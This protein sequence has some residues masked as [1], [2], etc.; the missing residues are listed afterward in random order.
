MLNCKIKL[1]VTPRF[2]LEEAME[3]NE[4]SKG[5][6]FRDGIQAPMEQ[7]HG[8][9]ANSA[10]PEDDDNDDLYGD[11]KVGENFLESFRKNEE[12]EKAVGASVQ[13]AGGKVK[14]DKGKKVMS[15]KWNNRDRSRDLAVRGDEMGDR[16]LVPAARLESSGDGGVKVGSHC[17]PSG[18]MVDLEKNASKNVASQEMIRSPTAATAGVSGNAGNVGNSGNSNMIR[19]G[20]VSGNAMG[21]IG[22]LG[23]LGA[24]PSG[25]GGGGGTIFVSHLHWW[26]TDAQLEA[27]SSKYGAVKE[28][29]CFSEPCNG[30]SKGCL[31]G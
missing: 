18:K 22:S 30:K 24:G 28:I 20:M 5:G 25:G 21:S 27:E 3:E 26:T 13:A 11:L 16:D 15:I 10:V 14:V 7:L 29:T 6:V 23:A 12:E 31:Q 1:N 9:E 17:H 4:A 19:Q 2:F 8:N